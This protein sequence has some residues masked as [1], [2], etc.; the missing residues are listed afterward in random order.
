LDLTKTSYRNQVPF[1]CPFCT[2]AT[3]IEFFLTNGGDMLI[4]NTRG[5][6]IGY[7]AATG[8]M[9]NEIPD[10]HVVYLKGVSSPKYVLP[11]Q[12]AD[13]LYDITVSGQ[14]IAEAVD[15]NLVV[16]GPGYVAGF[17]HIQLD[18]DQDLR[19][20]IRSDGTRL[21]FKEGQTAPAPQAFIANDA[22]G[23]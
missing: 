5:Q 8:Q 14:T 1:T 11:M 6:R 16:V 21:T 20:S 17:E 12:E 19:M 22:V 3:Q 13:K 18:P 7:D 9:L 10:A 23:Q 4:T 2:S 15:T